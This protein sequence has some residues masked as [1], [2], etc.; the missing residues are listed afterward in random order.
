MLPQEKVQW[1][2]PRITRLSIEKISIQNDINRIQKELEESP[3]FL[4]LHNTKQFLII[5]E[6]EESELREQGKQIML[7]N[8]LKKFEMLDGTVVQLNC[9]PWALILEEW[10]QLDKK[11]YK[12]KTTVTMD[13]VQVKKD[14]MEWLI[15]D[16][17]VT[18]ESDYKFIIKSK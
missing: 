6:K 1:L 2:I 15:L 3:L 9:T 13:K 17:G 4:E 12:E 16:P 14:F 18:I 10:V 11:Y 8:G 7:E 5:M